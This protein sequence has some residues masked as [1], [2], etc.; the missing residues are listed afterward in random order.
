MPLLVDQFVREGEKR[1][2][3]V[4]FLFLIFRNLG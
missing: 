2:W 3:S 4:F 1:A